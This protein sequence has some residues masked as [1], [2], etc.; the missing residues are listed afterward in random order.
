MINTKKRV[1]QFLDNRNMNSNRISTSG[2]L[3]G[4]IS[5]EP[6]NIDINKATDYHTIINKPKINNIELIGNKTSLELELQDKMEA[7]S[8]L[9]LERILEV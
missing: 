6:I 8:N 9:E 2:V 5:V 7:I 3:I 1:R 4:S